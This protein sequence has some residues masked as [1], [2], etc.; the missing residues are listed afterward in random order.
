MKALLIVLFIGLLFLHNTVLAEQ[1]YWEKYYP[2]E[3]R[4]I[5]V[6]FTLYIMEPNIYKEA[7]N[8]YWGLEYPSLAG[9]VLHYKDGSSAVFMPLKNIS[10]IRS[11]T[12][13]VLNELS[14]DELKESV[15]YGMLLE[16]IGRFYFTD[17]YIDLCYFGHEV[18]HV[19]DRTL[20]LQD[21]AKIFDLP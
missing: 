4:K 6:K 2:T 14:S 17:Q 15:N 10:T 13:K 8:L 21:R 1:T 11:E 9:F 12:N 7:K 20:V 5:E 19:V 16:H 18:G 3:I